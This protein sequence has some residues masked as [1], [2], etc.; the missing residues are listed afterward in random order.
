MLELGSTI[1]SHRGEGHVFSMVPRHSGLGLSFGRKD[2][3]FLVLPPLELLEKG[4]NVDIPHSKGN[5]LGMA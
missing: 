5:H 3:C 4:I 1:L 2:T